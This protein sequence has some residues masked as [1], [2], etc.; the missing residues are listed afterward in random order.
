MKKDDL[1]ILFLLCPVIDVYQKW[2]GPCAAVLSLFKRLR[3][4]VGDDLLRF[5]VVSV[6][7]FLNN[8]DGLVLNCGKSIHDS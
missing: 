3:N 6:Y 7:F 2:C 5:A 8:N 1:C 4:E